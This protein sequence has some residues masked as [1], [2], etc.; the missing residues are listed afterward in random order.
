MKHICIDINSGLR[1]VAKIENIENTTIHDVYTNR[2]KFWA[3]YDKVKVLMV[4]CLSRTP[5]TARHTGGIGTKTTDAMTNSCLTRM[6]AGGG[7]FTCGGGCLGLRD[8]GSPSLAS[9]RC[10]RVAVAFSRPRAPP[11]F[12]RKV[13]EFNFRISNARTDRPRRVVNDTLYYLEF[14]RRYIALHCSD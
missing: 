11:L 4:L 13:N 3:T 6:A 14:V 10:V 12:S 7:V 5:R 2:N 8:R 9:L 1:N